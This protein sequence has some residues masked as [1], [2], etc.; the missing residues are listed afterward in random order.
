MTDLLIRASSL[1]GLFDCAARWEAQNI[2][3]LKTPS[4]GP[5]H[6]GTSLHLASAK[7]DQARVEG[8]SIDTA[9]AVDLFVDQ[10]KKPVTADGEVVWSGPLTLAK[11]VSAG[12][13]LTMDYCDNFSPLR[14]FEAV[15]IQCAPI[16]IN[17]GDGVRITLTGQADRIRLEA[18]GDNVMRGIS[19][20]KS[21]QRIIGADGKIAVDKHAA[22][23]GQY[24]LI[25]LLVNRQNGMQFT[26]PAE[27]IAFPTS[28]SATRVVSDTV[29]NP[30]KLLLGDGGKRKGLLAA[31]AA[32]AKTGNFPGNP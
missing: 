5:A 18:D 21:G 25:E 8:S 10:V 1:P 27:I 22:Q 24:E 13:R 15:E 19:D 9:D 6:L 16:T 32:M 26:L 12:A 23:L 3:G 11:A 31:A 14:T 2:H 29:V 7:F 17:M 20:V 28:G 30:S 4:S